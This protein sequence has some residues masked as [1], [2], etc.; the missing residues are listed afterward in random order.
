MAERYVR[1]SAE[2]GS[3][4]TP[5]MILGDAAPPHVT[6]V[7]ASCDVASALRWWESVR[8]ELPESICVELFGLLFSV[9]PVGNQYAP[10]GGLYVGLEA[11]RTDAVAAAHHAV[12]SAANA[13]GVTPIGNTGDRYRPHLTLGVLRTAPRVFPAMPA[14]LFDGQVCGVPV[15][16]R[17]GDHGTITEIIRE[18]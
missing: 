11:L 10:Q 4:G 2:I 7:H 3:I 12:L 14:D 1:Y 17:L 5:D 16:G 6:L 18:T 9:I 8:H 15:L 13:A